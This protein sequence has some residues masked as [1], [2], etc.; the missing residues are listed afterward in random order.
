MTTVRD[1]RT[2]STSRPVV[3]DH[4]TEGANAPVVRDHRTQPQ[5][6]AGYVWKNDHW[7]RTRAPAYVP[8]P[9]RPVLSSPP[10]NIGTLPAGIRTV[11]ENLIKNGATEEAAAFLKRMTAS[12]DLQ[13]L[14]Q[15]IGGISSN[16]GV[17]ELMQN[18]VATSGTSE[19]AVVANM[20]KGSQEMYAQLLKDDPKQARAFLLQE[21]M[22][23]LKLMSEMLSNV[24]KTRA[25]ISQTF[26]RNIR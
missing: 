24:Q 17:N 22:A 19:A 7:E 11:Y 23:A 13:S 16:G 10:S 3:R 5:E 25:D 2:P 4:R 6:R 20:G 8:A 14:S 26:A 21:M 9:S 1:H 12:P 15:A 18:V